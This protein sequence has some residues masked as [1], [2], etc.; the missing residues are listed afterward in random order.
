MA[1]S[2]KA[3]GFSRFLEGMYPENVLLMSAHKQKKTTSAKVA[4]RKTVTKI[5]PFSLPD[6]AA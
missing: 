5:V 6:D 1:Y 3:A 2:G 4:S